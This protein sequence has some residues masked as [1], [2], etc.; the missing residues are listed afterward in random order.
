MELAGRSVLLT[1]ATGGIGHAIAR[2]AAARGATLVLSGRRVK[3]LE[4]LAAE[5]GGRTVAADLGD[6]AAV[7][8]LLDRVGEIDVL[9]ANAALPA[10]GRLRDFDDGEIEAAVAVNLTAPMQL[11]RALAPRLVERGSGHLVF[12]SSLSGKAAAQG[13]SIY[14]ATKFGLRGFSAALHAELG[15]AGV[16]VSC[17]FPGFVREAGMFHDSGARLPWFVGT[18]TPQDVARGVV[19]AIEHQ[20]C[21]VDVAPLGLR[22]GAALAGL[23]PGPVSRVNRLLGADRVADELAAG[24]RDRRG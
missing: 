20:R 24:Q 12:V 9:V 5:V 3:V 22:L 2:A 10:S 13:G 15:P 4:A 14:S 11:A 8:R 19:R 16:G 18:S 17:V 6:T 21:E 23:A 1:G 7:A